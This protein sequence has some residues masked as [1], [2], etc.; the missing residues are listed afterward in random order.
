M[1]ARLQ[2]GQEYSQIELDENV[3]QFPKM[4]QERGQSTLQRKMQSHTIENRFYAM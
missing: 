1:L 3:L 2:V 4:V